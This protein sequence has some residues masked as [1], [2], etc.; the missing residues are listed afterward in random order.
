MPQVCNAIK[1]NSI[2]MQYRLQLT[3]SI[4][5]YST[6]FVSGKVLIEVFGPNLIP[7]NVAA[8]VNQ[9]LVNSNAFPL[10]L[11]S[12]QIEEESFRNSHVFCAFGRR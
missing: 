8:S 1:I 4:L 10:K 3:Q 11:L 2:D 12:I 5:R 7:T 6:K 9:L